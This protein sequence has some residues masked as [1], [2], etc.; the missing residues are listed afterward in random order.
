MARRAIG[1]SRV[2]STCGS[3]FRSQRSLM[4]HPAPL[5]TRA[6][7]K[8]SAVVLMTADGAATGVA[9]VAATSVLK[10]H[11]KKR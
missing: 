6:P 7:V 4:V 10:R 3:R 11:G 5:M 9:I 2:R 8:K 1:R